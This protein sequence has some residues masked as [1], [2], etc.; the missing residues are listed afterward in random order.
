LNAHT[1]FIV[2]DMN[3]MKN[4]VG[5]GI[6]LAQRVMNLGR[7]GQILMHDRVRL[8]LEQ[9]PDYGRKIVYRDEYTVPPGKRLPIAQF[10]DHENIYLNNELLPLPA[11]A[12]LADPVTVD[13]AMIL[14]HRIQE[15][16]LKITLDGQAQHHLDL[17]REY[18]EDF[19]DE[20]G[21][22]QRL[23]VAVI[24]TAG[25]MLDN[26]FRYGAIGR[27][28]QVVFSL[29]RTKSSIIVEVEQPD[30]AGFDLAWILRRRQAQMRFMS[31]MDRR[32]LHWRQWR[33]EARMTLALEIPHNFELGTFNVL[34]AHTDSAHVTPPE[35]KDFI[36]RKADICIY[37]KTMLM[38]VTTSRID[39]KT[40]QEFQNIYLPRITSDYDNII[41]DLSMIQYCSSAV[42]RVFLLMYRTSTRI[43]GQRIAFAS[44]SR[45]L[46]DIFRINHFDDVLPCYE[47]VASALRALVEM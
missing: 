15:N 11:P 1:D 18:I 31:L 42:F 3:N 44:L 29:H 38:R 19:L 14:Q 28:G 33:S 6:N 39:H 16:L 22:F 4:V 30:V 5:N 32:G 23:K 24:W 34:H 26:A 7:P 47:D 46:Q 20:R 8:D 17:V 12:A 40:A 2:T 21:E 9:Y 25:E 43:P 10:V 37:N 45:F 35:I 13:L 41:L 36:D 27:D